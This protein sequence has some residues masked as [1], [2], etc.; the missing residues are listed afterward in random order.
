MWQFC[1]INANHAIYSHAPL[2]LSPTKLCFIILFPWSCFLC[3]FLVIYRLYWEFSFPF[4]SV[5]RFPIIDRRVYG[6]ISESLWCWHNLVMFVPVFLTGS[7][8]VLAGLLGC[9]HFH[10]AAVNYSSLL[11]EDGPGLLYVGAREAIYKLD[12]ANISD[13]NISLSVS[14]ASARICFILPNAA[15]LLIVVVHVCITAGMGSICW[16]EEAVPEQRKEQSGIAILDV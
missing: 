10:G 14:S 16:T 5:K 15:G 11:L 1:H 4:I 6:A 12:T 13:T 2:L 3:C 8:S 9:N 7:L